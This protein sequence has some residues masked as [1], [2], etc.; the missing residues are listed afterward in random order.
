[1]KT[2][3][4][5]V[6]VYWRVEDSKEFEVPVD[7]T[8]EDFLDSLDMEQFDINN[9]WVTECEVWNVVNRDHDGEEWQK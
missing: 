8:L 5:S 9:G 6:E 1:M 7:T 3:T 2:K 4:F